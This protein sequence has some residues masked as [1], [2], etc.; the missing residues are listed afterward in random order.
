MTSAT[1]H[2]PPP[3]A[4]PPPP[5]P[6]R[7]PLILL[8]LLAVKVHQTRQ[9]SRVASSIFPHPPP[10]LLPPLSELHIHT[11]AGSPPGLVA[12]WRNVSLSSTP[13]TRRSANFGSPLARSWRWPRGHSV[14]CF[15]DPLLQN[16]KIAGNVY[17]S[18]SIQE[19]TC[20]ETTRPASADTIIPAPS[21]TSWFR[22]RR[23]GLF[24]ASEPLFASCPPQGKEREGGQDGRQVITGWTGEFCGERDKK[25]KP[26]DGQTG[27]RI[28]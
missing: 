28:R 14:P 5:P 9:K 22:P 6:S 20:K 4:P 21:N 24:S 25:I 3:A 23:E 12:D 7:R 15:S 11:A 27:Q 10:H 19:I 18:L 1:L 17:L 8:D 16:W 26:D 2:P 13:P